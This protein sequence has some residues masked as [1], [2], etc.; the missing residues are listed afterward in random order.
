[1]YGITK[2]HVTV[3][4]KLAG[5]I[6]MLKQNIMI[7]HFDPISKLVPLTALNCK[8]L[9]MPCPLLFLRVSPSYTVVVG[10][11]TTLV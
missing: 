2:V 10:A 3:I 7:A 5:G 4:P 8:G 9:P 11:T 6:T 1:M